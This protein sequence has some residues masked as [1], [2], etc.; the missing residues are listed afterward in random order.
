MI[1]QFNI[2]TDI[3]EHTALL[4]NISPEEHV[5]LLHLQ[6]KL[7]QAFTDADY[8]EAISCTLNILPE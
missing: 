4:K 8:E 5:L 2:L 7:N 1:V 6:K 3:Q